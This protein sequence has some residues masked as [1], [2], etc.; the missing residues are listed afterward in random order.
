MHLI[1]SSA[2]P[3]VSGAHYIID[4]TFKTSIKKCTSKAQKKT[5]GSFHACPSI[6]GSEG[7]NGCGFQQ[8]QGKPSAEIQEDK[9]LR[10]HNE[11]L[12]CSFQHVAPEWFPVLIEK[13]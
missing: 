8:V 6:I 10:A 7:G 3:I 11:A 5:C 12:I 13:K 9:Q 4:V 1:E 2:Q